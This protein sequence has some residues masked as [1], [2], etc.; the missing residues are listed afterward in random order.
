[1]NCSSMAKKA[2]CVTGQSSADNRPAPRRHAPN[3]TSS[4]QTRYSRMQIHAPCA[5]PLKLSA[6]GSALSFARHNRS[7]L[8]V[9]A[10]LQWAAI[11]RCA[12]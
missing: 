2:A 5:S 7:S 3:L 10:I 1:M 8:R 11:R 6:Q 4:W 12:S 9:W